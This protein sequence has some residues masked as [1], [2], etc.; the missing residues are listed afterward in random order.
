MMKEQQEKVIR[1]FNVAPNGLEVDLIYLTP[2]PNID[3]SGTDYHIGYE[4]DCNGQRISIGH[5]D[6][7][8]GN[9]RF[10][11]VDT[12]AK[13]LGV[14]YLVLKLLVEWIQRNIDD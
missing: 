12:D 5:C 6:L 3:N 1:L 7:T 14:N 11:S 13:Y 9:I 8:S 10:D 2:I 4:D